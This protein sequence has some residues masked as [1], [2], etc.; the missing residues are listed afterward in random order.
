M[1]RDLF[2]KA[3][4]FLSANATGGDFD[5]EAA[6][7]ELLKIFG[8]HPQ[9]SS[10]AKPR[11]GSVF[12]DLAS[13]QGVNGDQ[14]LARVEVLTD[15]GGFFVREAI[16]PLVAGVDRFRIVEWRIGRP[17]HREFLASMAAT[18]PNQVSSLPECWRG[19]R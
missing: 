11:P 5:P 17:R 4:P 3:L 19:I 18:R 10:D 1:S 15:A 6:P 2:E 16:V 12:L 8:R 9:N 7:D 13:A 14:I